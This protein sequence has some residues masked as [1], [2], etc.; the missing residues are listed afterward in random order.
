MSQYDTS[1]VKQINAPTLVVHARDDSLVPFDHAE[2]TA[3]NVKGAQLIP[4][5]KGGHLALMFSVN[6]EALN[7][8]KQFLEKN[9]Q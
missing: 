1:L 2:F 8:V 7:Q 9:N 4:L 3:Q 6:A 5:E